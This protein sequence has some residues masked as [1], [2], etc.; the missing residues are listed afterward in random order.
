[1]KT[2]L[3]IAAMAALTSPVY[4]DPAQ[5]LVGKTDYDV[6]SC[7]GSPAQV[8]DFTG[9]RQIMSFVAARSTGGVVFNPIGATG[10]RFDHS[11]TALVHLE[12]G[13]ITKVEM[14]QSGGFITAGMLCG[15]V[16]AACE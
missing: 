10:A 3:M 12:N 5:S 1:M 13:I 9:G 16:L 11:C 4:A 15:Q 7:A 14:K 8:M 2:A 6:V